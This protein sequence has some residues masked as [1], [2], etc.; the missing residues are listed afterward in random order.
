MKI[1]K[2]AKSIT[3]AVANA[4][5]ENKFNYRPTVDV[6]S[7]GQQVAHIVNSIRSMEMRFLNGASWNQSE[8]N[9]NGY[10]KE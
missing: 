3:L 2:N 8:P 10:D 1:W 7:F 4:M 9:A 5:P 6:K